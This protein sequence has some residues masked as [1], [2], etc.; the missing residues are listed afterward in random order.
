MLFEARRRF[1]DRRGSAPFHNYMNEKRALNEI[2]ESLN[3][4]NEALKQLKSGMA[5]PKHLLYPME[6]YKGSVLTSGANFYHSVAKNVVD[7][8]TKA[9][10]TID[11]KPKDAK[12][13][14][15]SRKQSV[16]PDFWVIHELMEMGFDE[17]SAKNASFLLHG[18]STI[19]MS[20]F[21]SKN[22]NNPERECIYTRLHPSI[23]NWPRLE[24]LN[25]LIQGK[26]FS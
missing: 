16:E 21:L 26:N 2:S 4:E 20:K 9:T 24:D 13:D 1:G 22:R 19:D 5:D 3:H 8:L 25:L 17:I 7:W 14:A 23:E 18:Q 10:K 12:I 11:A 15:K 6:E